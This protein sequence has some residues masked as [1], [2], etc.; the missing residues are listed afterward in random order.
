MLMPA[1]R[2]CNFYKSTLSI[3]DFRERVQTLLERLNKLFIYRLAIRYGLVVEHRQDIV[4]YFEVT[5]K[6]EEE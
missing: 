5:K 2:M 4:F 3:E 6:G 1:C